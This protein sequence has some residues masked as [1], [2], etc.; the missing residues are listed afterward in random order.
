[1]I[2]LHYTEPYRHPDGKGCPPM[3]TRAEQN[4]VSQLRAPSLAFPEHDGPLSIKCCFQ[5]EELYEVEGG[6][7]RVDEAAYLVLNHG[8]RYASVLD[9]NEGTESCCFWFRTAFAER[10]LASLSV[11]DDRLLDDPRLRSQQ[12]ILFFERLYR[13]DDLVSPVLFR[14]REAANAGRANRLWLEEQ[15]HILVERLLQV[16]RNIYHEVERLPAT[17]QATRDELYRRLYRARDFLASSPELP[18][19]LSE[20]ADVA[21]LSPHYFLRQFKHLFCQTPHEYHRRARLERARHLLE[22]TEQSVT[23]ICFGLG[24]E[25]LGSFS[26]L[27]RRYFGLSPAQ[28]RAE[29]GRRQAIRRAAVAP[30][31]PDLFLNPR[32]GSL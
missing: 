10:A 28:Y 15:F 2:T 17:R 21:C 8:Q 32:Q 16:H 30:H 22:T 4:F 9:E 6:R 12:A 11:P 7:Y 3:P 5:G 27:F 1:M 14:I 29:H 26:W 24:F 19:T 20:A 18:V 23:E 25:S 13:H 31:S